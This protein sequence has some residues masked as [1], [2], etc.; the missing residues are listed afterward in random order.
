MKDLG[1]TY[2]GLEQ[3]TERKTQHMQQQVLLC[4]ARC[5]ERCCSL[6]E[7]LENLGIGSVCSLLQHPLHSFILRPPYSHPRRSKT[8]MQ[9]QNNKD[10]RL[11]FLNWIWNEKGK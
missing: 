5:G 2:Q 4:Q 11:E 1:M 6:G 8:H 3:G 7:R 9:H 10:E